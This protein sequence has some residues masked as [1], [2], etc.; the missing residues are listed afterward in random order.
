MQQHRAPN[1]GFS[2]PSQF[3]TTHSL[4]TAKAVITTLTLN[5]ASS[6]KGSVVDSQRTPENL[7]M[8]RNNESLT[9]Y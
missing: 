3:P 2:A 7:V 8:T 9:D 1:A 4:N 6:L 5:A